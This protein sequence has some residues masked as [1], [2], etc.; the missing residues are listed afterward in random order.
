M[1][2]GGNREGSGRPRSKNPRLAR[3]I[4]FSD[5]EWNKL[6]SIAKANGIT[7]SE[8][9]RNK[10]LGGTKMLINTGDV[11][12]KING[13][14]VDRKDVR[15]EIIAAFEDSLEVIISRQTDGVY[16]VY[17]NHPDADIITVKLEELGDNE[18]KIIAE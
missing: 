1:A 8:Y 7:A 6:K 5:D 9:I 18:V 3:S 13:L 12:S 16:Q 10:L 15:D 11:I 17:E 4:K 14:V 2:H